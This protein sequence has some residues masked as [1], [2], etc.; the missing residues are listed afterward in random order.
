M[1]NKCHCEEK[2]N[3]EEN[4]NNIMCTKNE[5]VKYLEHLDSN[6][7][8][9]PNTKCKWEFSEKNKQHNGVEITLKTIVF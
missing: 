4:K 6:P 9:N 8:S 7:K 2:Q 1:I 5:K 3:N